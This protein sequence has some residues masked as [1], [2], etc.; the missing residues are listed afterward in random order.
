MKYKGL[1]GVAAYFE[2][3]LPDDY[4][5]IK[6][7]KEN[8]KE[9]PVILEAF[10]DSYTDYCRVSTITGFPTI[11]GWSTHEWLWRNNN[12]LGDERR[13]EVTTIYE[14]NDIE[15]T[16]K[17]I[18]KY[19]IKYIIIGKL[20]RVKFKKLQEEKL[21]GLGKVVFTSNEMKVIELRN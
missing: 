7:L 12:T 3:N 17:I 13:T 4:E 14:S 8:E 9:Q 11:I 2:K 19:K 21:I 16:K 5:A 15:V 1:D 6:W 10:G 20:E 18:D